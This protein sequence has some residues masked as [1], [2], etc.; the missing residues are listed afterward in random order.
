MSYDTPLLDV[1]LALNN[2]GL[3]YELVYESEV[4]KKR[5]LNRARQKLSPKQCELLDLLLEGKGVGPN[6]TKMGG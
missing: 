4:E 5:I 6:I 2:H 3:S 1:S